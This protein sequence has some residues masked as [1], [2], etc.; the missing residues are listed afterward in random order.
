MTL[1]DSPLAAQPQELEIARSSL[2][3][4]RLFQA[5]SS[6]ALRLYTPE[7]GSQLGISQAANIVRAPELRNDRF[8]S[9]MGTG[10]TCWRRG[11]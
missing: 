10:R 4:L 8:R 2:A 11:S 1:E 6:E 7:A 5:K 9:R 3:N